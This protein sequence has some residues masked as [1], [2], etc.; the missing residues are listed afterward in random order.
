M[1]D[2]VLPALIC[3]C[4]VLGFCMAEPG[5]LNGGIGFIFGIL[6]YFV[7]VAALRRT[8]REELRLPAKRRVKA[9]L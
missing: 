6:S 9:D 4:L 2:Q 8:I 5:G 7:F 1:K 3:G